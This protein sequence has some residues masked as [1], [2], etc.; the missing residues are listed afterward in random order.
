MILQPA[1]QAFQALLDVA[2]DAVI[3]IDHRGRIETF[4]HAA[5]KLFGYTA[6][7]AVGANVSI[8]MPEPHRGHHDGYLERYLTSGI[9]HIIGIGREVD[10]RRKDGSLFPASLAI[11]RIPGSEPPRFVGFL[12]DITLRRQALEHAQRERDIVKKYAE[13]ERRMQQQMAHVSRLATMGEMAAGI[14]HELNQ[15]LAAITN[16]AVACERLLAAPAPD[17]AE[18]QGA[19][20]QIAGQALR[21]GEIIRRLRAL[22]R[23]REARREPADINELISELLTLA[24]SDARLNDVH[25]SFEPAV[26]LP[27]VNADG[28]QIQQVLLNLI[29]NAIEAFM[30]HSGGERAVIVRTGRTAQGEVEVSVSDTGPGV[31]PAIAG[32]MF[33][34]FCT[35]KEQGTGLGL[36]VSK[37]IIEAHRG[38]LDHRAD[39]PAGACFFLTLP[40]LP[41]KES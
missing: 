14:A 41:G 23:T 25:L 8:L 13:E 26:N 19:L 31:D 1:E 27:R 10:A 7:E 16:Y 20:Q 21:A 35:T 12:H 39:T 37:S 30:D 4:N 9:A 18:V 17:I 28:I 3:I 32:K 40:A 22:V 34:P 11:G 6:A 36:A 5:G 38:R 29:R 33:D 15:P 24:Q 2:V